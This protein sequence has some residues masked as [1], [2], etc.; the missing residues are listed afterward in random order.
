MV[1]ISQG[2]LAYFSDEKTQAAVDLLL[3]KKR[4]QMPDDVGWDEVPDFFRAVRAA[5][6]IQAD[7]AIL[8]HEIWNAV[9]KPLPAP[10]KA[11]APHEQGDD[12]AL[13]PNVIW[14]NGY[15]LRSFARDKLTSEL[16]IYVDGEAGVQ[17][18]FNLSQNTKSKLPKQLARWE[19]DD[20][21]FWS[22]S[23][24]VETRRNLNLDPLQPL[25]A[26]ALKIIRRYEKL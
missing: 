5:R 24:L 6:Q 13:D 25:A 9:W 12:G 21:T 16:H 3:A 8:L 22:P 15:L 11:K 23:A 17:I 7:Q 2:L 4:P 1:Q 18:G 14:S 10:W 19:D 20:G 26:E